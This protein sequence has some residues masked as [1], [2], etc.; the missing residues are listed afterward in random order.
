VKKP[1]AQIASV[2]L[3]SITASVS[4]FGQLCPPLVEARR[5]MAGA[6][7]PTY[8]IRT[9]EIAATSLALAIGF[10][11]TSLTGSKLPLMFAGLAAIILVATYEGILHMTPQE[12][13]R[14]TVK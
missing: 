1:D 7:S 8:D 12:I 2:A 10:I 13:K 5:N 11:G 9:G 3:L 6:N 4:I 14:G